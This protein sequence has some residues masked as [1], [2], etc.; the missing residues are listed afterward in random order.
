MTN[1]LS[2]ENW[3]SI[4]DNVPNLKFEQWD[5]RIVQISNPVKVKRGE[6]IY[7][8]KYFLSQSDFKCCLPK[9]FW[10]ICIGENIEFPMWIED[11]DCWME[12]SEKYKGE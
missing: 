3:I 8:A 2:N 12:L 7:V 4:K 9:R 11:N 5:D 1:K 10:Q 6:K